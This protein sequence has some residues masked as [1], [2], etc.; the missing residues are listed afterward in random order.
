MTSKQAGNESFRTSNLLSWPHF[1]LILHSAVP[2]SVSL[3][4]NIYN[5]AENRKEKKTDQGRTHLQEWRQTGKDKYHYWTREWQFIFYSKFLKVE[6]FIFVEPQRTVDLTSKNHTVL[7]D[8]NSLIYL[9]SSLWT[10]TYKKVWTTLPLLIKILF[11]LSIIF[12]GRNRAERGRQWQTSG[13]GIVPHTSLLT[14]NCNWSYLL[15]AW[16][17]II[18]RK[19]IFYWSIKKIINFLMNGE[20]F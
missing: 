8:V 10:L 7:Y 9:F 20:I 13:P 12:L 18:V 11:L 15:I 17:F 3:L 14:E 19:T 4:Q 6:R 16:Y 1:R 2:D 5:S